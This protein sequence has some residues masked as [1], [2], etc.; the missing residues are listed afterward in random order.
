[1]GVLWRRIQ[2][3]P[4]S[5]T[6]SVEYGTL[7]TIADSTVG[8]FVAQF[9]KPDGLAFDDGREDLCELFPRV[10]SQAL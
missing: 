8:H 1:M 9:C 10:F 5:N 3:W 6:T 2:H 7:Q 4:K